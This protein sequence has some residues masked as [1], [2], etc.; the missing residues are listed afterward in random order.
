VRSFL[1]LAGLCGVLA[2]CS[3]GGGAADSGGGRSAVAIHAKVMP[4]QPLGF[5]ACM[6]E[7][8]GWGYSV[9]AARQF[10][11]TA[12]A[13][14]APWFHG[15]F[16]NVSAPGTYIHCMFIAWDANGKRLFHSWLP[17]TEVSFPAGMYL[18]PHQTRSI[19]WYF[20]SQSYP[21][22]ARNVHAV[23]RYTASCRPFKNPPI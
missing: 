18:R 7:A 6:R 5:S 3:W 19:D 4:R 13:F 14:Q 21:D 20:D 1:L 9:V 11:C 17:L 2:G 10:G 8:R 22:A 15:T 12:S 23:A 16:T